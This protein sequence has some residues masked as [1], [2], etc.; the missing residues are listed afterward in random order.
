MLLVRPGCDPE[1]PSPL[2]TVNEVRK[3]F[4]HLPEIAQAS[5]GSQPTSIKLNT[6]HLKNGRRRYFSH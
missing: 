4:I 3:E 2:L 5:I 6:K 1:E